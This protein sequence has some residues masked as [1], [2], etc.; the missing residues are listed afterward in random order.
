MHSW[1]KISSHLSF[2]PFFCRF[3]ISSTSNTF[4]ALFQIPFTMQCIQH[5]WFGLHVDHGKTAV[6]LARTSKRPW[7]PLVVAFLQQNRQCCFREY[8]NDPICHCVIN[9]DASDDHQDALTE[10]SCV[11]EASSNPDELDDGSLSDVSSNPVELDDSTYL[12]LIF[13]IEPIL[14]MLMRECIV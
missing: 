4:V 8:L 9:A 2:I 5:T 13:Y 10:V 11:D 12:N 1:L 3:D 14:R 6:S 7:V